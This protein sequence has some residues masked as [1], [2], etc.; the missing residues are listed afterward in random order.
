LADF[1]GERFGVRD[2][3]AAGP[4]SQGLPDLFHP[5]AAAYAPF[6]VSK[7][8]ELG[9]DSGLGLLVNGNPALLVFT[10][11]D[12]SW[13]LE[14][15]RSAGFAFGLAGLQLQLTSTNL[16]YFYITLSVA[17]LDWRRHCS[18]RRIC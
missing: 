10:I 11:E 3:E 7:L 18:R 14:V 5:L 8:L 9:F 4:S 2:F 1:L 15:P 13:E 17:L 16:V 6:P 12:E